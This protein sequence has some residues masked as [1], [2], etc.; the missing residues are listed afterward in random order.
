MMM[1]CAERHYYMVQRIVMLVAKDPSCSYLCID[2]EPM[3][4][5]FF[6]DSLIKMLLTHKY[7]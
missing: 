6:S 1:I 2:K 5:T 3:C 4:V 7:M